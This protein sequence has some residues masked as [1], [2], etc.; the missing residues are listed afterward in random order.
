MTTDE[1]VIIGAGMAGCGAAY[2]LDQAGLT[3]RLYDKQPYFGGHTA[4]FSFEGG[5][6]TLDDGPH[7]SF[8]G[9]ARLQ[10]V[11]ADSV[12]G[13]HREIRARVDNYWRGLR[14]RH[15]V[16]AN[17]HGLPPDL[18][19]RC[20]EDFVAASQQPAPEQVATYA[21]WLRASLGTTLA[22]TFP[23]VYG[24]KYHTVGADRMSTDWLGP[25]I[26]RPTLEEVL[27]G[28]VDPAAGDVHYVTDFRYPE[29]GGFVRYLDGFRDLAEVHLAHRV[30]G[31]DPVT[32][33]LRFADGSATTY[34]ELICSMPLPELIPLV[35]GAPADVLA[36]AAALACT[37]CVLVNVVVDRED[38]SDAHWTYVYDEDIR[39]SRLSY[40]H[41]FS[42]ANVPPGHGAVQAEVY[43]SD[44][45]RPL[46]HDPADDIAPV[47]ADLRRMGVLRDEDAIV[48]S[49]AWT[50]PY[51]NV[52]FD[53]DRAAA[54]ELV[55]GFLDEAGILV[56]GRYGLWGYLWTD[57]AFAS[58]E[59]AA[60]R[61]MDRLG[62]RAR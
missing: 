50:V 22:E 45:Y 18:V 5:R 1:I 25:R 7:I 60:R 19:V 21:D 58:G 17:L 59:Q 9:N 27:R 2:Q 4:S 42:P 53:L 6:Y 57:Q 26:Y 49:T 41:M 13:G 34:Q 12:G 33:S 62:A 32:R 15:P 11:F 46:A 51:A 47:V 29:E 8:T 24:Q 3:A 38:L 40:P 55:H 20:I 28:A 39:A 43:Y 23:M 30:T 36:A 61:A 44:K 10:Q 54:L 56:C 14:P 48:F 16:Q 35:D 52:I 37:Q 31:V